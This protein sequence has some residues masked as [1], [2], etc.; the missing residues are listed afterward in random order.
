[1]KFEP[2]CWGL[3]RR[4]ERIGL[5]WRG[6]LLFLIALVAVAVAAIR[7]AYPFLAVNQPTGGGPLAVEGWLPDSGLQTAAD[8][9]RKDRHDTIYVTGGPL[10][11]G[12]FLIK[13]ETFAQ[14]GAATLLQF[15][16]SNEVV[17]AVPAP[18]VIKDRTYASA[19]ALRKWLQEHG[20]QASCL[21]VVSAGAHARRTRLLYEEAMGPGVKVG[22]IAVEPQDYN[23]KRWWASSAGF[24]EVTSEM[25]A[26]L[27][28]RWFFRPES[29]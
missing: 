29:G 27:Y 7:G 25:I 12:S 4:R 8:E 24:R 15:G 1:M 13:Y 18:A 11:R 10:D 21:E 14:L 5:T 6:R 23:P 16:F 22:I 3:L 9:F 19:M 2:F 26:Y 17:Q 20:R 28:A